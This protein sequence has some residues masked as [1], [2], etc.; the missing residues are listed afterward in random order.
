M[1]LT[2]PTAPQ[3]AANAAT[4]TKKWFVMGPLYGIGQYTHAGDRA[5]AENKALCPPLQPNMLRTV[6]YVRHS[7]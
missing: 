3:E 4:D 1:S 7:M 5:A 6:Y 2:A